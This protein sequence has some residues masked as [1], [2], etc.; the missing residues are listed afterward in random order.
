MMTTNVY[1]VI[2]ARGG[3]TGLPNKNLLH[4]GPHS[5]TG[6][7]ILYSLLNGVTPIVSTDSVEIA[8]EAQRYGVEPPRL[9]A[10]ELAKSD[11]PSPPV[12]LD[13]LEWLMPLPDYPEDSIVVLLEPTSPIRSKSLLS[14]AV[15][16]IAAG[17]GSAAVSVAQAVNEHPSN[18]VGQVGAGLLD[19]LDLP[20][21]LGRPR[22]LLTPRFY[23]EGSIYASRVS[24]LALRRSFYHDETVLL[25]GDRIGQVDVDTRSDM[26]LAI[27]TW[28]GISASLTS[29]EFNQRLADEFEWMVE[30]TNVSMAAGLS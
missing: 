27:L 16:K 23:P 2:T 13:A 11:T 15:D 28:H 14:R 1:T 12:V 19:P 8:E 18:M 4:V 17:V 3:S 26:D 21:T 7:A 10:A 22:Q 30:P 20:D 29:S 25:H 24:R 9:R 5:L 6:W